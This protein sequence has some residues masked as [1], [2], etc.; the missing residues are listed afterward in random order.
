MNNLIPPLKINDQNND[1]SKTIINEDN[2]EILN[3]NDEN[4]INEI[5][6][7][8]S[9][10]PKTSNLSIKNN[11]INKILIKDV[12][13]EEQI[14]LD[15]QKEFKKSRKRSEKKFLGRMED[16][17]KKRKAMPLAMDEFIEKSKFKV[18]EKK[19][20]KVYNRLIKDTNRRYE[21]KEKMLQS[22][23]EKENEDTFQMKKNLNKENKK[24]NQEQWSQIYYKRFDTFLKKYNS[25]KIKNISDLLKE[26]LKNYE[27]EKP[28]K[29]TKLIKKNEA[30]RIVENN[31]NNLYNDF[32][33]RKQK[34][35]NKEK[36]DTIYQMILDQKSNK[37]KKNTKSL[38]NQRN[39]KGNLKT[40][41][42]FRSHYINNNNKDIK[43]I[44]FTPKTL[45]SNN[46]FN[47]EDD[48]DEMQKINNNLKGEMISEILINKFL[49]NHGK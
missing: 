9:E 35:I 44:C 10:R 16:D 2:F 7:K 27:E 12:S 41:Q 23:E 31:I 39:K 36:N 25:K 47:F 11:N 49:M 18:G 32:L 1:E 22:K 13:D 3:S 5:N 28:K 29:I 20:L 30:K 40:N 14:R 34:K 33:I 6:S 15:F 8:I 37:F 4:I 43:V 19:Q 38:N 46:I 45:K 24:Y 48:D 42:C 21:S 26:E 17:I